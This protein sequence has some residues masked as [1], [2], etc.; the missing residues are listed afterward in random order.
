M[1]KTARHQNNKTKASPRPFKTWWLTAIIFLFLITG[2][3]VESRYIY[4]DKSIYSTG[5]ASDQNAD[6][7]ISFRPPALYGVSSAGTTGSVLV[8]V[9]PLYPEEFRGFLN[10]DLRGPHGVPWNATI[11]SARL[12]IFINDVIESVPNAG[13]PLIIDLVS[14]SPPIFIAE[15]FHRTNLLPLLSLP[16]D[17][18]SFD[19]GAIVVI[20]VTD[21]M[22]EAQ[23][24]GLFDFQLRLL[25]DG[26]AGS[27]LIEIDDGPLDTAPFLIVRYS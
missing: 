25:L 20:D 15:D 19:T 16:I 7:D 2:C 23:A 18:F 4:E 22:A 21:M 3:R 10:F 27:G 8:G 6:G 12:E 1:K 14:Y 24:R 17:I 9:D 5:I 11:E 26:F 13:I